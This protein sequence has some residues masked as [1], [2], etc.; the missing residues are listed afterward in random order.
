VLG[1]VL[2]LDWRAGLALALLLVAVA[3]FVV[4]DLR[5]GRL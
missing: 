4:A 5:V 1:V 2:E 3:V